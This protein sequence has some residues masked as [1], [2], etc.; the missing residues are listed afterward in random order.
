MEECQISVYRSVG[1]MASYGCQGMRI[2]TPACGLVRND[3]CFRCPKRRF[4]CSQLTDLRVIASQCSHWRGNPFSCNAQHC[5][6]Q[7][8]HKL[9]DKLQF[10][11]SIY[12]LFYVL[13]HRPSRLTFFQNQVTIIIT[14]TSREGQPWTLAVVAIYPVEVALRADSW[15][16]LKD[17]IAVSLLQNRKQYEKERI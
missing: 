1:A 6:G 12:P 8:R 11:F 4:R 17:S 16:A 2:A 14:M 3:I 5:V 9:L 15:C 10:D 13:R 7:G